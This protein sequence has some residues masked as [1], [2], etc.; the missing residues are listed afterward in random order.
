MG[1]CTLA[2]R[3]KKD[4]EWMVVLSLSI[5]FTLTMNIMLSFYIVETRNEIENIN[6]GC[7]NIFYDNRTI[8]IHNQT[9]ISPP[10]FMT[11]ESYITIN[12]VLVSEFPNA[13]IFLY[14][15]DYQL[16]DYSEYQ[17]F[18][19]WDKTNMYSYIE[20]YFDCDDFA[21]TLFGNIHRE[22]WGG[23]AFGVLMLSEPP[24]AINFFIDSDLEVYLVEPQTDKIFKM[25]N[26]W[27]GHIIIM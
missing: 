20:Y 6:C 15:K 12:D 11:N 3:I 27:I 19:E 9:N 5:A 18:I 2:I 21:F 23:L 4:K 10:I 1:D 24:H 14:D 26:N 17:R 7:S 16:T 25:P 8:E 22:G 13:S